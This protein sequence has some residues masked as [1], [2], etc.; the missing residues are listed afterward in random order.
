[1]D[2]LEFAKTEE[3]D[4]ARKEEGHDLDSKELYSLTS[5]V[6]FGRDA[7]MGPN[8]LTHITVATRWR[9]LRNDTPYEGGFSRRT[10]CGIQVAQEEDLPRDQILPENTPLTCLI[11]MAAMNH[12][13]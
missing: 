3:G 8:G 13:G 12:V 11:C 1:M 7:W 6:G 5:E 9:H 2:R 4:L 10:A